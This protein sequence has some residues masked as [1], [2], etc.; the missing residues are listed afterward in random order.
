MTEPHE[1]NRID[2][3]DDGE[4]AVFMTPRS[5]LIPANEIYDCTSLPLYLVTDS[6]GVAAITVLQD[7]AEEMAAAF[8]Q[9]AGHEFHVVCRSATLG[10]PVPPTLS[11]PQFNGDVPF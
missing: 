6:W 3:P 1:R 4:D 9:Q 7:E 10:P 11:G 8:S 2:E 5:P